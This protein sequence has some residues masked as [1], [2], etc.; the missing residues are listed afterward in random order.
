[1]ARYVDRDN[2]YVTRANALEDN[3]RLYKV[4]KGK[5]KQ[6]AGVDTK[7][8]AGAW[9]SLRLEVQG[10]HFKVSMDEKLLFEA[11]DNTFSAAGKV[12]LWTK[13]DSVTHFDD[14]SV[15]VSTPQ[16]TK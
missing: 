14:L 11:D 16:E 9:H 6:F 12:G 13:A 3:V 1:M 10:K 5:R 2:Y 4:E 15:R 8:S 7:V